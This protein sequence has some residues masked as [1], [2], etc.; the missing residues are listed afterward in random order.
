MSTL[1]KI[2][3]QK[4]A[5]HKIQSDFIEELLNLC[6]SEIEKLFF[7]NLIYYLFD[8]KFK[9]NSFTLPCNEAIHRFYFHDLYRLRDVQQGSHSFE[10]AFEFENLGYKADALD[11]IKT[12]GLG[13]HDE[14]PFDDFSNRVYYRIIPQYKIKFEKNYRLDFAILA[15]CHHNEKKIETKIAIECDGFE[16]HSKKED[17]QKD[18]YKLRE[19]TL[20]GW[21]IYKFSGTEI[22]NMDNFKKNR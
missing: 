2:N 13:F 20:N 18:N 17:L 1:D 11:Y 22:Y 3:F 4:S 19:L 7:V 12:I 16:F 14:H 5:I 10:E 6:E 15:Q 21:K 9:L 8:S